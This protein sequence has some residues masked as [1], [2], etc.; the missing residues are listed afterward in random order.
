MLGGLP[1]ALVQMA[2]FIHDRGYSYVEFLKLY[3]KSSSRIHTRGEAPIEYGH[4]LNT[5]WNLSFQNLSDS[6]RVLG[7][8]LAF[9]DADNIDEHIL[10]NDTINTDDVRLEFLGDELE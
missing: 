3:Q 9:F 8:L 5:V 1:L 6:G 7:N 4:T 10:Q 2:D